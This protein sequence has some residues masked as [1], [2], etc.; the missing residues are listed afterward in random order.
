MDLRGEVL[1][2]G[3]PIPQGNG[4]RDDPLACRHPGND[5]L[6]QVGRRLR[7]APPGTRRTKPPPLA[8]EGQQQLVVAGVT[9]QPQKAVCEDAAASTTSA[10]TIQS[11]CNRVRGPGQATASI[12]RHARPNQ[13]DWT[14][15][16]SARMTMRNR[17]KG[18]GPRMR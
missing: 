12:T 13:K 5:L 4:H 6:N 11:P 3:H 10:A 14:K 16:V 18:L 15:G 7:H 9:A 1:R 8:A 17:Q 2:G